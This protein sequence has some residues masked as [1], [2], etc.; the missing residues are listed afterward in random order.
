MKFLFFILALTSFLFAQPE[1][2]TLKQWAN[3]YTNILSSKQL[4]VLNHRLKTF[5]DSTTNQLVM[6]MIATL[7]DYPVEYYSHEVA[8]KNKI[9]TEENNN[10]ALLFIA[11]NDK[12]LRIEVGYG[13]E[14]ALPD[15]LASSIIRNV[16]VPHFKKNDFYAGITAGID[17]IIS[18]IAGEY[19]A[20]K[21]VSEDDEEAPFISIIIMIIFGILM[22]IFRGRGRGRRGGLIYLGGLGGRRGG[23]SSGGFGGF[24]GGGGSFGGGGASGSW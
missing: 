8:Q 20:E 24:S 2:P 16:I 23:F 11:K 9:G 15:A 22:F 13:L 6:L 21:D 17:V 4:E 19:R 1:V 18:A 12:K 14:G 3:D 5:E 10:G 7:N